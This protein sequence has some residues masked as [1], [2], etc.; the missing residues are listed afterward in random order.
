[1]V[2]CL[3]EIESSTWLGFL[4]VYSIDKLHTKSKTISR[5][6]NVL[7]IRDL[8]RW[9]IFGSCKYFLPLEKYLKFSL[10]KYILYFSIF[11]K[12]IENDPMLM[13]DFD[14]FIS[15]CNDTSSNNEMDQLQKKFQEQAKK[16]GEKHA[17]TIYD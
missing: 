2:F 6:Y 4:F 10:I 11:Y 17:L 15:N 7:S 14:E 16:I 12:A 3:L 1:M 5:I 9:Q 8:G 13:I